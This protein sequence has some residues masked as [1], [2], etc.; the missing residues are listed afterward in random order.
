ML[1]K[2]SWL[3]AEKHLHQSL[4]GSLWECPGR[5]LRPQGNTA[6][7]QENKDDGRFPHEE[8]PAKGCLILAFLG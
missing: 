7:D 2:G 4:P 8:S 6:Q 5:T 1:E 3:L